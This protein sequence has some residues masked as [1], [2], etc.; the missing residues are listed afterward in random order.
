LKATVGSIDDTGVQGVGPSFMSLGGLA[1]SPRDLANVMSI[2]MGGMDFSSFL[3]PNWQ[4]LRIGFV[5]PELWQLAP[6]VVEPN[7]GFRKQS[8]SISRNFKN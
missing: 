5:D 8:V 3:K 7:E 1:K 4:G 2:L 6:F